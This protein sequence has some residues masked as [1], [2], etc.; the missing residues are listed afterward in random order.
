MTEELNNNST[1]D[2][3]PIKRPSFGQ[4]MALWL[5]NMTPRKKALLWVILGVVVVAV[6]LIVY[7]SL[8][9]DQPTF[10]FEPSSGTWQGGTTQ[11]V[12][13]RVDAPDGE[14]IV[15]FAM[16]FDYNGNFF[17][18]EQNQIS[19]R[20]N[21]PIDFSATIDYDRNT[22]SIE[23]LNPSATVFEGT[24]AIVAYVTINVPDV[25]NA[26]NL[27][28][29]FS[30]TNQVKMVSIS[31]PFISDR[32]V[33][34]SA[35]YLVI[36]PGSNVIYLD[37]TG[38]DTELGLP[39]SVDVMLNV[40][41]TD[42]VAVEAKIRYDTN[43]LVL[44]SVTKSND[45][46]TEGPETSLAEANTNGEYYM[47]RGVP[48]G[49]DS[50]KDSS[51]KI[52]TLNFNTVEITDTPTQIFVNDTR[53]VLAQASTA[54]NLN[55]A[56]GDYRIIEQGTS[57]GLTGPYVDVY[58]VGEEWV[59]DITWGTNLAADSIIYYATTPGVDPNSSPS[60][61]GP[62][63]TRDHLVTLNNL[64]YLATYYFKIDGFPDEYSFK[65]EE[66][67]GPGL[68]IVNLSAS[69]DYSF[70]SI[71]WNTVG[72]DYNG[73]ANSEVFDC[74]PTLPDK[75]LPGTRTSH[76]ID[77]YNLDPETNYTCHVRSTDV[78][79]NF[80]TDIIS[81]TTLPGRG[82]DANIILKV[83]RDRECDKWLYCRSSVE[84]VNSAGEKE[85]LCFDVGLCD[86]LGQDGSC[87]RPITTNTPNPGVKFSDAP[88]RYPDEIEKI[89]N[90][91]GMAKVGVD[92]DY[93]CSAN[94]NL[95][96]NCTSGETCNDSTSCGSVNPECKKAVVNGY[97]S[98]AAM[99]PKGLDINIPNSGFENKEKWPWTENSYARIDIVSDPEQRTNSVLQLTNRTVSSTV[100]NNMNRFYAPI[101]QVVEGEEYAISFGARTSSS[102]VKN[103]RVDLYINGQYYPVETIPIPITN[104]WQTV[105]L[106]YIAL[107]SGEANL[108]F[109]A[110]IRQLGSESIYIDNVKMKSVLPISSSLTKDRRCRLYPSSTAPD[111][112]Y[113]DAS[114]KI[115]HG[116]QGFCVEE[117]PKYADSKQKMCLNWWP[118]DILP[119]ETDVFG[120]DE[121]AGYLGRVPLYYCLEADGSYEY[122]KHVIYG[123]CGGH[124]PC[125]WQEDQVNEDGGIIPFS[126][127]DAGLKVYKD[128]ILEVRIDGVRIDDDSAG[129]DCGLGQD[130]ASINP[131]IPTN[132]SNK[133]TSGTII[134]NAKNKEHWSDP[135]SGAVD[136]ECGGDY[137]ADF[138]EYA[139]LRCAHIDRMNDCNIMTARLE[140][141]DETDE[142]I[143][144]W[145]KYLDG[146]KEWGKAEFSQITITFKGPRC[147]V[148]AQVVQPDG[149]AVPWSSRIKEGGWPATHVDNVLG[150]EYGQDYAPYGAASVP[151]PA[152]DPTQWSKPLYV[153]P[154]DTSAGQQKPY[155]ARAG[156]PYGMT[157]SYTF[158]NVCTNSMGGDRLCRSNDDCD[159]SGLC[160][161]PQN[162]TKVYC[163]YPALDGYCTPSNIATDCPNIGGVVCRG[164]DTDGD[165]NTEMESLCALPW[166]C[167]LDLIGDFCIVQEGICEAGTTYDK[168]GEIGETQCVA[169]TA[170]NLGKSCSNSGNCG[171]GGTGTFG[172]C[173]GI[174]LT[175]E[176]SSEDVIGGGYQGGQDRLSKLFAKSFGVWRWEWDDREE[177]MRYVLQTGATYG[178]DATSISGQET[179]KPQVKNI[180]VNDSLINITIDGPKGVTLKFN[181]VV[182][183]DHLPMTAYRVDW[184]DGT[185]KSQVGNLRIYPRTQEDNPHVLFHVYEC[186]PNGIGWNSARGVCIFKPRV[187]VQDN[188]GWCN[189]GVDVNDICPVS[190][191]SWEVFG[192][193]VVVNP[194]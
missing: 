24:S 126:L 54:I 93:R 145:V 155:Q 41:S 38:T 100:H 169:G 152:S 177:K 119:G 104:N 40:G 166:G 149:K 8:A 184:G 153:E 187:Q 110:V 143:N 165:P 180:K 189:N 73:E 17:T 52:V 131:S 137:K 94:P 69:P 1:Q 79:G 91:S 56:Q 57:P 48:A 35:S 176:Q 178:W 161:V 157:G 46:P 136:L 134:F 181:A 194:R 64:T 92:W 173:M 99:E 101:G 133:G 81:F 186:I 75:I 129:W 10:R 31:N 37:P 106:D 62:T 120:S 13:V 193:E 123:Y 50:N 102:L 36:T 147:N 148:L 85:N 18:D 190:S 21:I 25:P 20:A 154:A 163:T 162:E 108:N 15:D 4:R 159:A 26:P 72:G 74:D 2:F 112:D 19:V 118:V 164:V 55:N 70:T 114:G 121:Q 23:A 47:I 188:W 45:F 71:N 9:V 51:V 43:Y 82:P 191:N 67:G 77:Y 183:E 142:L 65:V 83:N 140:F 27:N 98:Y 105:V 14:S 116:W 39:L 175:D 156:S 68:T 151:E 117:D 158:G 84:I 171:T 128:E 7:F 11:T 97:F 144:V 109:G 87:I 61:S 88:Y 42:V 135:I 6:G 115:V 150:Y 146:S 76:Q 58:K 185:P 172:L 168:A 167:S 44:D 29:N 60:A 132:D 111:C 130:H 141:D 32:L 174:D 22:I 28:F 192:G 160:Y 124:A 89:S 66:G 107:A 86:E 80:D 53:I 113:V 96:C 139:Y 16:E 127:A 125:Y 122:Y 49:S 170:D 12:A 182:D 95:I 78:D 5:G 138:N 103:M 59:A 33:L 179:K 34:Q 30:G 3:M 63:N 90:L